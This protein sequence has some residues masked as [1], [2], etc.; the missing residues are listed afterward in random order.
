MDPAAM[1]GRS[2]R[3][4]MAREKD[5][6]R[7]NVMLS[8]EDLAELDRMAEVWGLSRSA[9]LRDL[10]SQAARKERTRDGALPP[11]PELGVPVRRMTF[12]QALQVARSAA[13]RLKGFDGVAEIRRW[14]E[15]R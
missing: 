13:A 7:V 14:R 10:V 2:Q 5:L 6:V 8:R 1:A 11:L 12:E 3:L 15:Q 9:L 4:S